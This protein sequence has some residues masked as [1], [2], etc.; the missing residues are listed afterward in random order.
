MLDTPGI[1]LE[2]IKSRFFSFGLGFDYELCVSY[3]RRWICRSCLDC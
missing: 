3:R 2:S 1:P